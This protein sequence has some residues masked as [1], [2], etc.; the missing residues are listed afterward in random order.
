MTDEGEEECDMNLFPRNPWSSFLPALLYISPGVTVNKLHLSS[1]VQKGG[2]LCNNYCTKNTLVVVLEH[3]H[4]VFIM[5][6]QYW[7]LV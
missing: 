1:L 4:S 7:S 2:I 3:S 6:I 5:A